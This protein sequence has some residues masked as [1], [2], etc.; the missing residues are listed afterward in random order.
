MSLL[1]AMN[2]AISG[3]T[4][5]SAAFG[6][7]S[8]NVANSQTTGY[9]EVATSFV[10]YLT[11][12]TPSVNDPG[13]VVAQPDYLNNVQGTIT[14]VTNPLA[15]AIAG[16]GFFAVSQQ[17]GE[18][19]GIPTF[20]PQQFYSRAGDFQLNSDG[21]LV[22]SAGQYL[23]GWSVDPSTGAV[24][25]NSLAPI[26]VTQ[27]VYN[28]VATSEVTLSA[29]LPAS[30]ATGTGT[31]A[32]PI[33]SDID[34]YDSLGTQHVITLNWVQN[35]DNDWTVSVVSPDDLN[36]SAIGSAE[37]QFGATSGNPVPEG[38]VGQITN[39]TG[40]VTT[41]G[42][43]ANTAATLD[44]TTDFGSGPQTIE[45]NL[46]TY[47]E[48]NGVTQY[49]G[50]QYNL[51]GLTQ[52]GVPP[53]SFAGVTPQANGDIVVNYNNGQTRT[54]AQV[55][56]VTFNDPDTLQRQDGQSFTAT[57]AS[58]TPLAE[59]ASTN[60]AGNLVIGSVESSNVDIATEFSSLIVAQQAYSANAKMVT[61]AQQML[62]TTVDMKQ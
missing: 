9:K 43:S 2:T 10:D 30:P 39:T 46:G 38:T 52:N 21:Y 28:P 29:N 57:I 7:I 25:Q 13:A 32:S 41:T 44:F 34:V 62:Q 58:G 16:Q 60:G 23:N 5:Q 22:N 12:S 11:T 17:T 49:A 6:D 14:Q 42:Y 20:N 4:S 51:E 56:L 54:I 3:L 15:M 59:E 35:A 33:S 61:T 37:V 8:D 1:G 47:G 24:N 53:G 40:N 18:A 36:A 31:A 55:P 26:K 45:L 19:N 50:S 48:T 27:T